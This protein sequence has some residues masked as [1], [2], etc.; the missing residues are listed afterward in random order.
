M[1]A[2]T[3]ANPFSPSDFERSK[4]RAASR[5]KWIMFC[6][7]A[8]LIVPL[9][10]ILIDIFIKAWPAL[11]FDY[12]WQ[13]PANKGKAG[14]LWAPLIGTFYLV[15]GSLLFVAPVGILAA[16]YLNEYANEGWINRIIG[17]TV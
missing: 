16:I 15:I 3:M 1:I 6:F 8:V 11:S 13:N 4:H 2:T 9:M 7:C 10:W 14:G 5:N 17:I 12:L